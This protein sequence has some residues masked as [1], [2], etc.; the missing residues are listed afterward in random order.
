MYPQGRGHRQC[1]NRLYARASLCPRDDGSVRLSCSAC[2][3]RM[4]ERVVES[5]THPCLIDGKVRTL[6]GSPRLCPLVPLSGIVSAGEDVR[7]VVL[8]ACQGGSHHAQADSLRC[9]VRA[10]SIR[11]VIPIYDTRCLRDKEAPTIAGGQ[12]TGLQS[13]PPA[14]LDIPRVTVDGLQRLVPSFE[15]AWH[16]HGGRC[17]PPEFP[18]TPHILAADGLIGINSIE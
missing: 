4:G 15:A 9:R 6:L 5:A 8:S 14:F 3:K 16:V 17:S 13:R 18:D 11:E 7:W 10:C 2:C 1:A 12:F